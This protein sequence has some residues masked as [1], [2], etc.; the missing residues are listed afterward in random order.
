[1]RAEKWLTRTS[2]GLWTTCP[3]L[4]RS[5]L[6][7][8]KGDHMCPP[9]CSSPRRHSC[10]DRDCGGI[11]NNHLAPV[12]TTQ[13][14]ETLEPPAARI[15]HGMC[16]HP[17]VCLCSSPET[18]PSRADRLVPQASPHLAL[19]L[20]VRWTGVHSRNVPDLLRVRRARQTAFLA[21]TILQHP[22]VSSAASWILAR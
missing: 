3:Y 15:Q 18:S 4:P 2:S 5:N 20:G 6:A 10:R 22:G 12:H 14:S 13:I 9:R 17:P 21:T 7:R 1:M 16:I 11:D 19:Q 8:G